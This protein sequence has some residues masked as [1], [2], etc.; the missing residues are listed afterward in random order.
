MIGMVHGIKQ[1]AYICIVEKGA[2]YGEIQAHPAGVITNFNFIYNAFT[3]NQSYFQ[4]TNRSGDGVTIL[5]PHTNTFDVKL[6]YRFLTQND[7]DYVGMARSYQGYLV[8]KG[9]LKKVTQPNGRIGIK[10]EFLSGDKQK[11]LLWNQFIGMTTLSQMG[12]ILDGLGIENPDVVLYGWQP[13]GAS[14][15]PPTSLRLDGGLGNL[16]Q[17]RTLTDKVISSGG[18]FYLYLDPQA[19]LRDEGG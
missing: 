7:S 9:M 14:S 12:N 3:Y 10:L 4:A 1:N 11:V 6:Q 5:Q 2:S 13:L 19:A 17:L 15:M 16:N 18:N 8:E